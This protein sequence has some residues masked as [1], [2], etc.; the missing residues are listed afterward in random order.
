VLAFILMMLELVIPDLLF[1]DLSQVCQMT[2]VELVVLQIYFLPFQIQT[3]HLL[4]E[5]N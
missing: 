2:L 5:R 4:Q 1:K 3:N